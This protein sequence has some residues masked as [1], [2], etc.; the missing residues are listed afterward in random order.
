MRRLHVALAVDDL[1]AT[2]RD[3]SERLGAEPIAVVPGRYALWRTPEVNLSVNSDVATGERLRHLGFED[4][5]VTTKSESTDVNG[6]LWESFSPRWQNEGI[7]RVY[8]PPI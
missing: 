3:Y 4:D 1:V 5:A 2:V 7:I 8:G 6:L